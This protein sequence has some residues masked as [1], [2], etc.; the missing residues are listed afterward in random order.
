[1]KLGEC[2][3]ISY[4]YN[5]IRILR[6]LSESILSDHFSSMLYIIAMRLENEELK[7]YF[8]SKITETYQVYVRGTGNDIK[9]D[10][11]IITD[12]KPYRHYNIPYS[13]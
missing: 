8:N 3:I 6:Q 5:G 9:R 4:L 12:T 10:I 2:V 13:F 11:E 1:M 7:M